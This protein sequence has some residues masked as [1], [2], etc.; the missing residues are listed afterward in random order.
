MA[1]L[2]NIMQQVK[3]FA[4]AAGKKTE[5]AVE[6]SKLKLKSIQLN[7][8]V[9]STYERIGALEYEQ[10]RHSADNKEMIGDCMRE[11]DRLLEESAQINRRLSEFTNGIL[12]AQCNTLNR[13]EYT[14]CSACGASLYRQ[15]SAFSTEND[16]FDEEDSVQ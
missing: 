7:A 6:I 8:L 12:C 13:A 1:K 14:Y 5:K 3:V 15:E 16:G 9:Q 4:N 10:E 11:V 2:N